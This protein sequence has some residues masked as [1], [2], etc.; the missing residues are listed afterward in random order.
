MPS[1][2][3]KGVILEWKWDDDSTEDIKIE[4]GKFEDSGDWVRLQQG[5]DNFYIRAGSWDLIKEKVDL[6]FS[7]NAKD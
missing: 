4:A 1:I 7:E 2:K 6:L 5:D 3:E